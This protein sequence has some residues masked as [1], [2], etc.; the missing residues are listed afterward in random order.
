[1]RS[2][3]LIFFN[4]LARAAQQH[5]REAAH[6]AAQAL[7]AATDNPRQELIIQN[8][9]NNPQIAPYMTECLEQAIGQ[10]NAEIQQLN[11]DNTRIDDAM[12]RLQSAD[13]ERRQQISIELLLSTLKCTATDLDEWLRKADAYLLKVQPGYK[14]PKPLKVLTPTDDLAKMVIQMR[15]AALLD[16]IQTVQQAREL[17]LGEEIETQLQA[18]TEW[19]TELSNDTQ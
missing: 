7:I 8:A 12:G 16:E 15:D 18:I 10:I 4:N 13:E 14:F 6:T 2:D 1:M 3:I 5:D 9:L 19:Y 17:A 11:A